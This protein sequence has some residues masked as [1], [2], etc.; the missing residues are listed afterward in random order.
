MVVSVKDQFCI[1]TTKTI[2][3]IG[4]TIG[5]YVL[6]NITLISNKRIYSNLQKTEEDCYLL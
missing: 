2:S 3:M 4:Y 5:R 1:S 6:K